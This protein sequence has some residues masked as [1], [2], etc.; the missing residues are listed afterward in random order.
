MKL[1]T[2]ERLKLIE[3]LKEGFVPYL[4]CPLCNKDKFERCFVLDDIDYVN[5]GCGMVF[6]PMYMKPEQLIKYYKGTYRLSVD[7]HDNTVTEHNI[8]NERNRGKRQAN[9]INGVTPKRHLDIGSST[10]IFL[11]MIKEKYGCESLGV[12][13][14]DLF[15]EYSIKSGINTVADISEVDGKFDFISMSHVL[16]HLI[17][18]LE[19]LKTVRGLL[20]DDGQLFVEV[21]QMSPSFAHPLMFFDLSLKKMLSKAGFK[22]M[23]L[24]LKKHIMTL[25]RKDL[26]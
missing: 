16:E 11:K 20:E 23:E 9:F 19:M 26:E 22:V 7:T 3:V 2:A 15:R 12:E 4:R 8:W 1:N 24:I 14:G 10:G 6:Q 25:A 18:P 21:P 5:C 17:N 13:P